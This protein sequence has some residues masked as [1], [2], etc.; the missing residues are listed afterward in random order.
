MVLAGLAECL[1][2]QNLFMGRKVRQGTDFEG[3]EGL[4]GRRKRSTELRG[5][6]DIDAREDSKLL[7]NQFEKRY[8][9]FW[10]SDW[11]EHDLA[12]LGI[13]IE[14]PKGGFSL[15]A[16]QLA[17]AQT[18]ERWAKDRKLHR[19]NV[20]KGLEIVDGKVT[21]IIDDGRSLPKRETMAVVTN[22]TTLIDHQGHHSQTIM[23][24]LESRG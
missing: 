3:E 20:R 11:T 2:V 14:R 8:S 10:S 19:A 18:V 17:A 4:R 7:L 15:P 21:K 16:I 9:S 1:T 22:T 12:R 5:I 13:G 23:M 24:V 6:S